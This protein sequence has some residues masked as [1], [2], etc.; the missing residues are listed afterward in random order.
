MAKTMKSERSWVVV[1]GTA[2][3]EPVYLG[4]LNVDADVSDGAK[5][6]EADR[7]G[8]RRLE[9]ALRFTERGAKWIAKGY[10]GLPIVPAE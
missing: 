7:C 6:K 3:G 4:S 8:V 9:N 2:G 5:I 1:V 10:S